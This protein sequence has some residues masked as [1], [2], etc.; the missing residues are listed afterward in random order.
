MKRISLRIIAAS[1]RILLAALLAVHAVDAASAEDQNLGSFIQ[2]APPVSAG[3]EQAKDRA[4]GESK[5]RDTGKKSPNECP[6]LEELG[7]KPKRIDQ[8]SLDVTQESDEFPADCARELFTT[9]RASRDA[10]KPVHGPLSLEWCASN[11]WHQPI[12]WEEP[13][14]ER[15]GQ[16]RR[17][18]LQPFVSGAH[19]F[20]AFPTIPY[21]IGIARPCDRVYELGYYRPGSGAPCLRRR[22]V[23]E[24]DAAAIETLTALGLIFA[25]P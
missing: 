25:L 15:Y 6:S 1:S 13:I 9:V 5:D 7:Y 24:R 22:M 14:L 19:F 8:I 18:V 10:E 2:A 4:R 16:G 12:Y 23:W 17:H 21:Q 3:R 11:L 20:V